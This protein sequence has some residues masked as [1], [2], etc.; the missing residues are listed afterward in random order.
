MSKKFAVI[1]AGCGVFDGSEIHEAVSTLLA[2][3]KTGGSYQCFAPDI[4]QFHVINHVT[5]ETSNEI[6]NVLVEAARIARGNVK[7]IT[8]FDPD[9]FD[10]LVIPGGFG[11]AKNLC[12]FA[13]KGPDCDVDPHTAE[14]IRKAY[15]SGLPIGALCIAPAL[16]AKVL[17]KGTLTIGQDA[18][19]ATGI[20][21]LGAVHEKTLGSDIV[22]DLEN[23]LVTSPCYML[24]SSIHVIAEGAENAINALI[25]LV[26]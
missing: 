3:D 12:N 13:I 20:E 14:A 9:D 19:T 10:V 18:D 15:Q 8:E 6:R 17:G 5:G 23:K 7:A 21:K 1:L 24:D 22:V 11:V 26:D 16:I 2:I 4:E 25:E